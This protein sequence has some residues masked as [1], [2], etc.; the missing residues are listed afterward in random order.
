LSYH[1]SRV[2]KIEGAG[3]IKVAA[4]DLEIT[5]LLCGVSCQEDIHLC[6]ELDH[7]RFLHTKE[8]IACVCAVPSEHF[9][10]VVHTEYLMQ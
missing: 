2:A 10:P 9:P 1:C 6:L 7:R 3:P 4:L 5:D 8:Q